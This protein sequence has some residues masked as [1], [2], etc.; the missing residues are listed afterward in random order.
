MAKLESYRSKHV[1]SP[2]VGSK[3]A[4]FGFKPLD[5]LPLHLCRH[6]MMA[7]GLFGR[8][9]GQPP[10]WRMQQWT[11][12]IIQRPLILFRQLKSCTEPGQ[13]PHVK[14]RPRKPI[15]PVVFS[16][17][18]SAARPSSSSQ[19]SQLHFAGKGAHYPPE[20]QEPL[21]PL[22]I[23]LCYVILHPAVFLTSIRPSLSGTQIHCKSSILS[24]S[25]AF[26]CSVCNM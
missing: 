3:R 11:H 25:C 16:L 4:I 9:I 1:L 23:I 5:F 12:P 8:G 18:V 19:C 6:M 26:K 14:S 7:G 15:C 13:I 2:V 20:S 22:A 17:S 21:N 10:T 24:L